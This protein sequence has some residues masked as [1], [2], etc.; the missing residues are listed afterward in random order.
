MILRNTT[1]NLIGFGAPLL[2]AIGT[3]PALI[4]GLG[5][6]RFGLLTLIW[7]VV[8][9][10]GLLDL[11]LGR[12]LT[13]QLSIELARSRDGH[14]APLVWTALLLMAAL[15]V[16]AGVL[17]ALLAPWGSSRL[18]A[19]PDQAEAMQAMQAMAWAMPFIVLT[20]GLRG[21]LEARHAFMAINLIRLPMGLF[22]FLGPLAVVL[23]AR[24]GLD[25]IA[26][27]LTAGRVL[28]FLAHAW[29]AVR[30]LPAMGWRPHWQ[31]ELVRPL[32]SS[33]GWLAVSNVISPLMG[34]I[35]RFVIGATASAAAVAYYATPNE[36]VTKL[37]IIP[38]ALTT[39]LFP[40]FAARWTD[41]R[42]E[43]IAL[44][45]NATSG[46][47]AVLVPLTTLVTLY[48]HPLLA[49]W[50]SPEFAAHSSLILQI[51][52][53]GILVNSL[54]HIPFTLA[55]SAGAARRTGLLHCIEILPYAALLWFLSS[56][57]GATGAAVAWFIRICVDTAATFLLCARTLEQPVA[58]ILPRGF[59]LMP[60]SAV[61]TLLVARLPWP[62]LHAGW[63]VATLLAAGAL[64]VQV[65]RHHRIPVTQSTPTPIPP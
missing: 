8:S 15:G 9:Y 22:T 46:L 31:R 18:E 35:D 28:G 11:G 55:Q 36:L 20:S 39:V 6:D 25:L 23:W 64:A 57:H 34:Y 24:P 45:K 19:V 17:L 54:A 65:R 37:W 26:W 61:A 63:A 30:S 32:C 50:I 27:V 3:I 58:A 1:L 2:V 51:F 7:A 42:G 29:A 49:H 13:Q 33:G 5:V 60:L 47:F 56:R 10:F 41:A 48:A 62:I 12:A 40:M 4:E 53:A 21:V 38:G 59:L 43:T 16:A 44:F 14:V 52:G